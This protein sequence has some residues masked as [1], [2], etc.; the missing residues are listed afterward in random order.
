[1]FMAELT[2]EMKEMFAKAPAFPVATASKNG[3]PNV[4]PIKTVWLMDDE[5]IWIGDNFMKKTLANL[6]ENPRVSIYVWGPETKGC[7]QIKGDVDIKTSGP[8]YEDMRAKIKAK[9]DK[10]PAKSL[11][12]MKITE[13]F[14]CSPGPEAGNRL[15]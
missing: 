13:V 5:T 10:H 4:V 11:I 1:M 6:Q 9:S 2:A 8:E 7:L 14:T 12:I 3:E 15:I